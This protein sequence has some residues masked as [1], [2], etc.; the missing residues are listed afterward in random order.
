[1]LEEC[2]TEGVFSS[3][4]DSVTFIYK[5]SL[6]CPLFPFCSWRIGRT[7]LVMLLSPF[8]RIFQ[9]VLSSLWILCACTSPRIKGEL[10]R[11]R[12]LCENWMHVKN[13]V[14]L[15]FSAVGLMFHHLVTVKLELNYGES[16]RVPMEF[17][18]HCYHTVL[19]QWRIPLSQALNLPW[20]FY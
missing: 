8:C 6:S 1:M 11:K 2:M 17:L 20:C 4:K 12:T 16:F 5:N 13:N 14:A 18:L 9:S 19:Q 7:Y 15:Q 10:N 3:V